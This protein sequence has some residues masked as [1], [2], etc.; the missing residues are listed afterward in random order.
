MSTISPYCHLGMHD[1]GLVIVICLHF[2]YLYVIAIHY[3]SLYL[4]L[5]RFFDH[6]ASWSLCYGASRNRLECCR[7]TE[8]EIFAARTN[9]PVFGFSNLASLVQSQI[10]TVLGKECNSPGLPLQVITKM[11]FETTLMSLLQ[12]VSIQFVHCRMTIPWMA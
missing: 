11:T 7:E 5:K 1:Q 6:C 8:T 2:I 3:G 12:C 9:L 10:T 4:S